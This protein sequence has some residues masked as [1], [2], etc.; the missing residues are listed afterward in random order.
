MALRNIQG[1]ALLWWVPIITKG[2]K[3]LENTFWQKNQMYCYHT[4]NDLIFKSQE[5]FDF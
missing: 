2:W 1:S 3:K 5:R 4:P